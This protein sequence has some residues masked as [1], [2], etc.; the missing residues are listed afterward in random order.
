MAGTKEVR[1][2]IASITSTRKITSAM[3]MVSAS[4]MRRAQERMTLGRP[5]AERIREVIGHLANAHPEHR[6][7]YLEARPEVRN[8]GYVIISSDRGLCG[9]LNNNLLRLV[10]RDIG[11]W[12]SK[13]A[14]IRLC[15][16]GGKA[17][18]FFRSHGGQ[19]LATI[20]GLGDEP[21]VEDLIGGIKVML[22][23]FSE[24]SV[25]LVQLVSNRF[26]NTMVQDGRVEQ[27]LPLPP[28]EQEDLG[29]SW[30][31]LYEPDAGELLDGLMARYIEALT[32]Q[33]VVENLA[34]EQAARMVA[35]KNATENAGELLEELQL[36]YNKARQA[37]ITQ[38]L[39]EIVGGAAAV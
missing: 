15:P 12:M 21:R 27:L 32:Y 39:S 3:E 5:Y 11:G 24:G 36:L 29:H 31:Y 22:D 17:I 18:H 35:M 19:V 13:G 33:A 23:A 25:D 4:K 1:N 6:H 10:T 20:R 26:V 2:K 9:G 14:G 30:D 8:V 7:R 37:S 16:V 28:T 38:E 34:C